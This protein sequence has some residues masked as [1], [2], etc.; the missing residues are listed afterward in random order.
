MSDPWG[1]SPSESD[2]VRDEVHTED[3]EFVLV[4]EV[5]YRPTVTAAEVKDLVAAGPL[6]L[7][8]EDGPID[9]SSPWR[10]TEERLIHRE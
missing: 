2:V 10:P 4:S 9:Q 3:I 6:Q 1:L 7:E 8:F 5:P